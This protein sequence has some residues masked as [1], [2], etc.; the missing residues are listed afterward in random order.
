M[1]LLDKIRDRVKELT[2]ETASKAAAK[3]TPAPEHGF[4]D[5]VREEIGASK[6]SPEV[7]VEEVHRAV[8]EGK[9]IIHLS[10]LFPD[11]IVQDGIIPG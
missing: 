9:R 11:Q 6:S 1:R 10:F 5:A 7:T 3:E 8:T 2:E 4:L